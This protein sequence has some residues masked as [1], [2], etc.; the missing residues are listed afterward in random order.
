ML[1]FVHAI[2]HRNTKYTSSIKL[3]PIAMCC[4]VYLI[5]MHPKLKVVYIFF[6]FTFLST[7]LQNTYLF[8]FV[9]STLSRF[10]IWFNP[11]DS[12]S[13]FLRMMPKKIFLAI[14]FFIVKRK[15]Q[16][17]AMI[18]CWQ[19][20]IHQEAQGFQKVPEFCILEL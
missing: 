9:L 1:L 19:F 14:V 6:C 12:Q 5:Y 7:F 8:F 15:I 4:M 18:G 10:A 2:N 13:P 17:D 20:C 3:L 16:V 11:M